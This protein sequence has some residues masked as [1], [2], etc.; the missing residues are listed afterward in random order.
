MI[1]CDVAIVGGGFSGAMVAAHLARNGG[2]NVGVRLFEAG[3]DEIGRGAAYGTPHPQH[4]LNTRASAMSAYP[5]APDHFVRWLGS[6]AS[7]DAFLSRRCFGD[8][9]A[10][11]ARNAFALPTFTTVRDLVVSV[12]RDGDLYVVTTACGARFSARAVVLATGNALPNDDFLPAEL[13]GYGRYVGDPWRFD[14]SRV[15]GD[16]LVIGSGLTAIDALVAMDS[17]GHRGMIHIVSRHARFPETHAERLE[18]YEVV[19]V[20]DAGDARSLV[21]SFRRQIAEAGRRGYDWRAVVDAIRP[22]AETIWRRLSAVE[23][24]RFDRHLRAAWERHRHRVPLEVDATRRRYLR[25]GRLVVHAGRVAEFRSSTVFVEARDGSVLRLRPEWILNCTGTGRRR[26][27]F[28]DPLIAGLVRDGL[29]LPDPLGLGIRVDPDDAVVT[30]GR[31]EP[32]TMWVVGPLAR[33]SR[34]ESTAVP[35]LRTAAE[36]VARRAL[37]AIAS[38]RWAVARA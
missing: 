9:V 22:E 16:V 18:R 13:T 14:Y 27:I 3:E 28:G 36:S 34:F 5:G 11:I 29:A 37:D 35:E 25:S 26:R 38:E 12:V 31:S 20:L 1:R 4:L 7:P 23:Q 15:R 10:E 33:G 17:G 8:Y 21:R 19:P 24:C 6:N 32:K 2:S 30:A